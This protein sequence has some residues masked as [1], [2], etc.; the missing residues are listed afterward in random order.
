MEQVTDFREVLKQTLTLG[1]EGFKQK[2]QYWESAAQSLITL[3]DNQQQIERV[4]RDLLLI[5]IELAELEAELQLLILQD[6]R[7]TNESQ[8]KAALNSTKM[9]NPKWLKLNNKTIPDMKL[10]LETLT[11]HQEVLRKAYQ[12][13]Y[14]AVSA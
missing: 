4:K 11:L 9:N 8:R 7:L 10:L 2:E 12:L 13:C 1:E 14:V 3:L 5:E 6:K